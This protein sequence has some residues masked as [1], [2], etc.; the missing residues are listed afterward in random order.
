MTFIQL[1]PPDLG[2]YFIP[3]ATD[4]S[5]VISGHMSFFCRQSNP[6]LYWVLVS[7]AAAQVSRAIS[8]H[9]PPSQQPSAEPLSSE[10]D[11]QEL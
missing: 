2:L 7:D 4:C 6:G 10:T 8:R 1:P 11:P 9:A 3:I 5:D